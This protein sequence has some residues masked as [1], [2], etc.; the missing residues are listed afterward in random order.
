[1]IKKHFIYWIV[2]LSSGLS[3]AQSNHEILQYSFQDIYG[4][5][6]V[7]SM[8]GAFTALGGDPSSSYL[9]PAGM[10]IKRMNEVQ[11]G[12]G[13]HFNSTSSTFDIPGNI[14]TEDQRGFLTVPDLHY[15]SVQNFGNNKDWRRGIWTFGM[16][17][18]GNIGENIAMSGI[19][20]FKSYITNIAETLTGQEANASTLSG[21][22]LI[23]FQTFMVDTLNGANKYISA[24]GG[25]QQRILFEQENKG[26]TREFY[27]GYATTYKDKFY[28]GFQVS[29]P[30]LSR[31]TYTSITESDYEIPNHIILNG[32]KNQIDFARME[33]QFSINASALKGS[34]GI[35]F[36]PSKYTRLGF[37]Y[38]TP[39]VYNMQ[40]TFAI[41]G[42]T[43]FNNH[44]EL[45]FNP[46]EKGFQIAPYTL[47]IPGK[48]HLG[49]AII[50]KKMGLISIDFDYTNLKNITYGVIGNTL[51]ADALYY[52]D[53]NKRIDSYFNHSFS[54]RM[55]SEWNIKRHLRFRLGGHY[56]SSPTQGDQITG[57]IGGSA[58]FG[59]AK[60]A[61][62]WD[63]G[64][65]YS[66]YTQNYAVFSTYNSNDQSYFDLKSTN[67]Q[68]ITSIGYKIR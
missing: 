38:H 41:Q 32:V 14:S 17:K 26:S 20:R 18:T 11:F 56:T 23:A 37:S 31:N 7:I 16:N 9:N 51:N 28:M 67:L 47:K 29:I 6:R 54:V 13:G 59:F 48:V 64:A 58:G 50:L 55:G 62:A 53:V 60:K 19:G 42:T 1:M 40:E 22:N 61:F 21:R 63:I 35:L 33:H 36:K 8:G 12:I 44:G 5:A 2:L 24:N 4:S 3:F 39:Y 49:G 68:I 65:S 30:I 46:D 66:Q 25:D 52:E 27:L 15:V 43:K 57:R 10:G 34:L 45:T